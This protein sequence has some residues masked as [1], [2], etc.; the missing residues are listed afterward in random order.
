[1]GFGICL[2]KT[3]FCPIILPA[4]AI[5]IYL[6][7]CIFVYLERVFRGLA[8][9]LCV[10]CNCTFKDKQFPANPQSIGP[11]NGKS[12]DQIAQEIEWK[13]VEEICA[14]GGQHGAKLFSG[15]IEPADICQGQ[16]GDCWL[17][18]ALA[19]LADTE[20]AIQRAFTTKEFNAYGK[21]KVRL[22][23]RPKNK[24]VTVTV[25][26]WIPCKKGSNTP[27]FAQ[28]SKDEAWVLLLE[29]AMAKFKGSFANLDGGSSLWAFECLTGNYVFKFK[30]EGTPQKPVWKR[31]DLVHPKEKN[32]KI[33]LQAAKDELNHDDMFETLVFYTRQRSVVGAST[34]AGSDKENING[35][36]QGHAY[37]VVAAKEVD[38]FKLIRL[39]NPWGSFEWK[40]NWSD[41]S[42]LWKQYPKVAKAL[43]FM[44]A[45]DGMF[46]MDFKDFC[47]YYKNLDFCFR[48]T[49]WDDLALDIHEERQCLGPALGCI[50]GC[51]SYWFCCKGCRALWFS[52]KK[53]TFEKAPQGC[54]ANMCV[55]CAV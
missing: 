46:W 14:R 35:I 10:C 39:R 45:D 29:K 20:G 16:L 52:N 43:D 8:C 54:C 13:R 42:P 51:T 50:E 9:G 12:L 6:F 21:Y 37:S 38:Q 36:V 24:F 15:K 3:L 32:G 7:G 1:M 41:N 5:W 55:G 44:A 31:Y 28:P 34:G 27:C 4:Q 18:S 49:G 33:M 11:W 22:F 25:D 47:M 2:L 40:G 19:C 30:L 17:M 48:T 23:D 53:Q 26:D